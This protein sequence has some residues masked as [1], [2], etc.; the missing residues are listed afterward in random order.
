MLRAKLIFGFLKIGS[1]EGIKLKKITRKNILNEIAAIAFS[2][3]TRFA[4]VVSDNDGGQTV[5][6]GN[7][8]DLSAE[9]RRAV[10]G[11]KAGT[12]GIELKLYDKLRALELLG[13]VCGV[14]DGGDMK[15]KDAVDKLKEFFEGCDVFGGSNE[16][17]Q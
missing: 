10:A 17:E 6:V 9:C 3:F 13:R 15:E 14:F 5:I 12:R 16:A 11:F 8:A 1:R 7:T 4:Q 2:D